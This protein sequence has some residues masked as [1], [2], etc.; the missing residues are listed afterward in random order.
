MAG[1]A[2]PA[3][4]GRAASKSANQRWPIALAPPKSASARASDLLAKRWHRDPDERVMDLEAALPTWVT[5]T[6]LLG[7][8]PGVSAGVQP[9]VLPGAHPGVTV[10][11][12]PGEGSG[13]NSGVSTGIVCSVGRAGPVTSSVRFPERSTVAA[14]M[15]TTVASTPRP[16]ADARRVPSR[17]IPSRPVR[18]RPPDSAPRVVARPTCR[19]PDGL[20]EHPGDHL[21]DHLGAGCPDRRG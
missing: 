17:P 15:T 13:C 8:G 1:R 7:E 10:G 21:R 3:G 11:D 5:L 19:R 16:P 6:R 18:S 2:R 12:R 14:M 9:R 4:V 20:L